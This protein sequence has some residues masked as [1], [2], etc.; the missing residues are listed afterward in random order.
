MARISIRPTFFA[1]RIAES[2]SLTALVCLAVL[3]LAAAVEHVRVASTPLAT[4]IRPNQPGSRAL[5]VRRVIAVPPSQSPS[6]VVPAPSPSTP[7]RVDLPL[8]AVAT[9]Q[10]KTPDLP[11]LA[12]IAPRIRD[13]STGEADRNLPA[14][15]TATVTGRHK[16]V[17]MLRNDAAMET[18][19]G[20]FAS[21][22][23][24]LKEMIQAGALTSVSKGTGVRVL[25]V[26]GSLAHVE[27]VGQNRTGW[28]RSACIV[29]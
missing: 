20:E 10:T 15:G 23:D 21:G 17:P 2:V 6:P 1:C 12:R 3:S 16:D 14:T 18:W 9:L 27:I 19:G 24:R 13:M 5:A 8:R 28:I 22:D 7:A 11:K 26:R 4:A 25:E 29:R